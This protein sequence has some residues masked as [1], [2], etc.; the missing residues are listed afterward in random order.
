MGILLVVLTDQRQEALALGSGLGG[1]L[2][3][4]E[5]Q[6]RVVSNRRIH[7]VVELINRR[8]SLSDIEVPRCILL[9]AK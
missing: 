1:N 6:A 9:D 5:D 2:F 8:A 3:S 4:G 7:S